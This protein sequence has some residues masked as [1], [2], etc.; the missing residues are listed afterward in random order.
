MRRGAPKL[1]MLT[2]ELPRGLSFVHRGRILGVR[3]SGARVRSL[4]LSHGHLVLVLRGSARSLVV[5]LGS[6]ALRESA[7]MRAKARAGTLGRL[8]LTV[9]TR[10]VRGRRVTV[11]VQVN[12]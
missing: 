5:R 9:V 2:V 10:N 11:T 4:S 7:V 8:R 3:V 12:P 6:R 1:S